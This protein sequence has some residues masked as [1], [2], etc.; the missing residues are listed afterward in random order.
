[1]FRLKF[2]F[3]PGRCPQV[4]RVQLCTQLFA[5]AESSTV[6]RPEMYCEWKSCR[7]QTGNIE[8]TEVL[9]ASTGAQDAQVWPSPAPPRFW[10]RWSTKGARKRCWSSTSSA[11]SNIRRCR[12]IA[13]PTPKSGLTRFRS[14]GRAL[15]PPA[16][17]V[18]RPLLTLKRSK[19]E[20]QEQ[21]SRIE[22][23]H[24]KKD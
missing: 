2:L 9:A 17:R 19:I 12:V 10:L 15:P 22:S 4:R 7:R 14:T 5:P 20:L 11:R 13:S 16:K 1:M 18:G 3:A 6:W 8:F 21:Y 24:I 23:W